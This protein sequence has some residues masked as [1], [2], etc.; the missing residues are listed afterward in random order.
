MK[1][2]VRRRESAQIGL[3][4]AAPENNA[5][6]QLSSDYKLV[7]HRGENVLELDRQKMK[8]LLS[9]ATRRGSG[10]SRDWVIQDPAICP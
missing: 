3:Y 1:A 10:T 4:M 5:A 7:L 2:S 6:D 8:D 9:N